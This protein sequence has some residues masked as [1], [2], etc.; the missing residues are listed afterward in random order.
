MVKAKTREAKKFIAVSLNGLKLISY[1]FGRTETRI[2]DTSLKIN[3]INLIA[4][5]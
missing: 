2:K 1:I 4:I 5:S 3:K